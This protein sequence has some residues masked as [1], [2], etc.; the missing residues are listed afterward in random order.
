MENISNNIVIKKEEVPDTLDYIKANIDSVSKLKSSPIITK[1]SS[2]KLVELN[3]NKL[4][5][6]HQIM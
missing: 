4:D 5:P 6:D 3:L 2:S 1:T